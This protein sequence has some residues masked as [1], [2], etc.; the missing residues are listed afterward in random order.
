MPLTIPNGIASQSGLRD[1][2]HSFCQTLHGVSQIGAGN[3][4]GALVDYL[5]RSG[6]R[7]WSGNSRFAIDAEKTGRCHNF[8]A[9]NP[10]GSTQIAQQALLSGSEPGGTVRLVNQYYQLTAAQQ[11]S[12]YA[13]GKFIRHH[14]LYQLLAGSLAAFIGQILQMS[15]YATV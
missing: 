3:V 4:P 11:G 13:P 6:C 7:W 14:L 12:L 9:G 5:S 8:Q 2:F 1:R 15:L 10:A